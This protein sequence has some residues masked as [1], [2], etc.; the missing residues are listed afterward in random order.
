MQHKVPFPGNNGIRISNDSFSDFYVSGPQSKNAT[1][2]MTKC[3]QKVFR[4]RR[5]H[6]AIF[7]LN[8]ESSKEE[9]PSMDASS[10]LI[11]LPI[12]TQAGALGRHNGLRDCCRRTLA[13]FQDL[14]NS[15]RLQPFSGCSLLISTIRSPSCMKFGTSGSLFKCSRGSKRYITLIKDKVLTG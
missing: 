14:L 13:S 15:V 1:P 2:T 11:L 6:L 4:C 9:M 10:A 7:N 5:T 8:T 12:V 3:L